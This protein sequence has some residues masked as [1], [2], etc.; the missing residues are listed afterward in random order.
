MGA[1]VQPAHR[2]RTE[3]ESLSICSQPPTCA[4]LPALLQVIEASEGT[5]RLSAERRLAKRF[6]FSRGSS[7]L[8]QPPRQRRASSRHARHRIGT[9]RGERC[10][11]H[12]GRWERRTNKVLV[13]SRRELKYWHEPITLRYTLSI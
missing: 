7:F 9:T 2:R 11:L 8:G 4:C 3:G 6:R 13:A 10:G 1:S 5:V 12:C